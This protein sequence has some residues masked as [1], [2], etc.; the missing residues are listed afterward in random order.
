MG[1]PEPP[2]PAECREER[3]NR[4]RGFCLFITQSSLSGSVKNHF[5]IR[6]WRE[7]FLRSPLMPSSV[8]ATRGEPGQCHVVRQ[9]EDK[10]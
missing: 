1:A 2:I 5:Q 3:V 7:G 6:K 9:C 4:E 10:S 8:K